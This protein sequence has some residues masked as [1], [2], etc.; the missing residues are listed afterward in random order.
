V[1]AER[2]GSDRAPARL[3]VR[4]SGRVQGVA[5]R[6]YTQEEARSLALSGWVR[7]LADGRVEVLAEGP[8]EALERLLEWCRQ[9]PSHARVEGVEVEWEESRGGLRGFHIA[10]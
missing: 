4:V 5:F 6:A 3:C 7:N 8:R 2:D 9:G 1:S 10:R